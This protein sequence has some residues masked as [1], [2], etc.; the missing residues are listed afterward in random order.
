MIVLAIYIYSLIVYKK[1]A[2]SNKGHGYHWSMMLIGLFGAVTG[3]LGLPFLTA[4]TVRSV[5][6]TNACQVWGQSHAPGEKPKLE[7]VK[8]QRVTGLLI[9]IFIGKF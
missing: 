3:V 6:H 5:T 8:E 2:R 9:H 1:L 4:A 7:E